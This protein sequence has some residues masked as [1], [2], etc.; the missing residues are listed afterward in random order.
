M[1]MKPT[2]I[3]RYNLG[4]NSDAGWNLPV[5]FGALP[6]EIFGSTNKVSMFL[7]YRFPLYFKTR[8]CSLG[9]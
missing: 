2:A 3:E 5:T 8:L 6:W 7:K 1:S 4:T 9:L